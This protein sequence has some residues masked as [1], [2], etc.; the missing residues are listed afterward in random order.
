M[1]DTTED[2]YVT[3]TMP[4]YVFNGVYYGTFLCSEL[5]RESDT[6]RVFLWDIEKI[7]F[8]GLYYY[9]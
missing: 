1:L 2:G 5:F 8:G 3:G 6:E 9:H 7:K 4:R